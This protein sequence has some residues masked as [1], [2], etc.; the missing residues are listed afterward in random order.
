MTD[1]IVEF[2]AL[3]KDWSNLLLVGVGLSAF[4]VYYLQKRDEI[5]IAATLVQGQIDLVQQRVLALKNDHQL[6][7]ISVYHSQIILQENLWE[8]YKHL[9][10]KKIQKSDAEIIQRF[11]DSAEQIERARSDMIQ[12]LSCAW[13]HKSLVEHQIVGEYI[14]ADVDKK[15]KTPS[16]NAEKVQV[17]TCTYEAFRKAYRPLELVFTPDIVRN[18]LVKHL[19]DFNLLSGTTAYQKIQQYSYGK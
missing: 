8:K 6:G 18:A 16:D 15:I 2:L 13:E 4:V 1:L 10:I 9:L 3:L 17:E 7:I 19:N 5:R 14:K 12:T 11:F